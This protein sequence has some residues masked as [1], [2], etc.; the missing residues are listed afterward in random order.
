M[1]PER[2]VETQHKPELVADFNA[3]ALEGQSDRRHVPNHRCLYKPADA[4]PANV[5]ATAAITR[6]AML[7]SVQRSF[8]TFPSSAKPLL[9]GLWGFPA[10]CPETRMDTRYLAERRGF[11]PRIG[12]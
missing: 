7:N 8:I 6:F 5:T 11:E 1:D 3:H 12:Y 2:V 9:G 10:H 4:W